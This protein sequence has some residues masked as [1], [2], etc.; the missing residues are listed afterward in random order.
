MPPTLK[1]CA[2]AIKQVRGVD[3]R[4]PTPYVYSTKAQVLIPD[5][6]EST[7]ASITVP[8]FGDG[9]IGAFSV[10]LNIRH[11][12]LQDLQIRLTPPN[13]LAYIIMDRVGGASQKLTHTQF[14]SDMCDDFYVTP[15]ISEGPAP[16]TGIWRPSYGAL[17][18]FSQWQ[19]VWT[20]SIKD[21][22]A[23]DSGVL[24]SFILRFFDWG[25]CWPTSLERLALMSHGPSR[26]LHVMDADCKVQSS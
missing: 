10:E 1:T 13:N 7:T 8:P 14:L 21:L 19:G 3:C 24:D 6:T 11:R 23:G 26:L 4:K 2:G 9:S 18:S 25:T 16:F 22:A 12:Y 15:D 20:I 5:L 17:T